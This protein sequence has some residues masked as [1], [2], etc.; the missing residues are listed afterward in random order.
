MELIYFN[1]STIVTQTLS[2]CA[3]SRPPLFVL[4]CTLIAKMFVTEHVLQIGLVSFLNHFQEIS[5]FW[6]LNFF[7]WRLSIAS[8]RS[9]FSVTPRIWNLIFSLRK[10]HRSYRSHFHWVILFIFHWQRPRW[11]FYYSSLDQHQIR[12][13]RYCY[14]SLPRI[15]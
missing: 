9:A 3:S 10:S 2:Q 7:F 15:I 5:I 12:T 1:L 11:K 6:I 13:G 14:C 8:K 4:L